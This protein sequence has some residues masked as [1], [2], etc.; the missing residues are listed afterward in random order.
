M[1]RT[2]R[3]LSVAT[4][5]EPGERYGNDDCYSRRI[6][7]LNRGGK[8]WANRFATFGIPFS[9]VPIWRN[10]HSLRRYDVHLHR[11]HQNVERIIGKSNN[12]HFPLHCLPGTGSGI[13]N[14]FQLC[15]V[16]HFTPVPD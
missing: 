9:H 4:I 7:F 5:D 1:H 14:H 13:N 15:A 11:F 2:E 3:I 16:V 10:A 12:N 6:L 8:D